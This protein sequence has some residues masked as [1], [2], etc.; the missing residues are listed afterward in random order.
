V[1]TDERSLRELRTF[2]EEAAR[3]MMGLETR[4]RTLVA[5]KGHETELTLLRDSIAPSLRLTRALLD[6]GLR[7]RHGT[8]LALRPLLR[9]LIVDDR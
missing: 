2:C 3:Q 9:A 1:H 6:A 8:L 5:A 4:L 7:G